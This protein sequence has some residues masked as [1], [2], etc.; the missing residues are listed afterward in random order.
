MES[1]VWLL[2]ISLAQRRQRSRLHLASAMCII[3]GQRLWRAQ[4]LRAEMLEGR[5]RRSAALV[6]VPGKS[7][8]E[9][10]DSGRLAECSGLGRQSGEGT[11]EKKQTN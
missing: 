1:H 3:K 9:E 7:L 5:Q 2:R 6:V 4:D 8:V 11:L 10:E